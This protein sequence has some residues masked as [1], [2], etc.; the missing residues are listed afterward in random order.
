MSDERCLFDDANCRQE[1]QAGCRVLAVYRPPQAPNTSPTWS[2][3]PHLLIYLTQSHSL[4][5]TS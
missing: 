3:C 5:A 2:T 1:E 4:T